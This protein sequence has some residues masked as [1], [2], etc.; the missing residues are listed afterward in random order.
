[1]DYHN[2]HLYFE[3]F[4]QLGGATFVWL[5]NIVLVLL[6]DYR[7][8]LYYSVNQIIQFRPIIIVPYEHD[9]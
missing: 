5:T 6:S 9:E 3:L 4:L 2:D 8:K 1:M 7:P